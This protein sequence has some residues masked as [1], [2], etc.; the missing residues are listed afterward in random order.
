MEENKMSEKPVSKEDTEILEIVNCLIREYNKLNPEKQKPFLTKVVKNNDDNCIVCMENT[1]CIMLSCGH[2]ALCQA[3]STV[4][5]ALSERESIKCPLCRKQERVVDIKTNHTTLRAVTQCYNL[6]NTVRLPPLDYSFS[7]HYLPIDGLRTF[8]GQ[9]TNWSQNINSYNFGHRNF[10][11]NF[12]INTVIPSIAPIEQEIQEEKEDQEEKNEEKEYENTNLQISLKV[13]SYNSNHIGCVIL[14][15]QSNGRQT[16]DIWF[17]IDDSGSMT[18]VRMNVIS[19]LKRILTVMDQYD[20]IGII[21]F[22]SNAFMIPLQPVTDEAKRSISRTFDS[23][24][25][26]G[27]TNSKKALELLQQGMEEAKTNETN[28][29]TL[30]FFISDGEPD[31]ECEGYDIAQ[32]IQQHCRNLR[33]FSLTFGSNVSY[34]NMKEYV[35]DCIENCLHCH[36]SYNIFEHFSG[37]QNGNTIATNVVIQDIV[38]PRLV[39]GERRRITFVGNS[40]NI[41]YTDKDGNTVNRNVEPIV[42]SVDSPESKELVSQYLLQDFSKKITEKFDSNDDN[43]LKQLKIQCILQ[44]VQLDNNYDKMLKMI[45]DSITALNERNNNNFGNYNYT[46]SASQRTAS[47]I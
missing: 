4:L 11:Q 46:R 32:Q 17:V 13:T 3:C 42:V 41:S 22:G 29:S 26:G 24:K 14:S 6:S 40:L 36:N 23:Y 31:R 25:D 34:D 33:F 2:L 45:N 20:R 37:I 47:G 9:I 21:I 1:S 39:Q 28:R 43:G 7:S 18:N 8:A 44:R 15:S 30:V 38:I 19:T 27:S 12:N 16:K 5:H 35:K 10:R